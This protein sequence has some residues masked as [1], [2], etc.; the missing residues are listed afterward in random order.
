MELLLELFNNVEWYVMLFGWITM[1]LG[2][3][4]LYLL[5]HNHYGLFRKG[6]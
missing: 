6:K 5:L 3:F 2:F 1:P 4:A